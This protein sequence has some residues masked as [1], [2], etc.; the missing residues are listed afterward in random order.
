MHVPA[1][2]TDTP[3]AIVAVRDALLLGQRDVEL[4]QRIREANRAVEHLMRAGIR[5]RDPG[6]SEADLLRQ[7]AE[8][9]LGE[10]LAR[11]V[12]GPR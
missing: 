3:P 8:I 7:V 2:L 10:D 6:I 11:R 9:R 1:P 12:Y 4:A 5:E